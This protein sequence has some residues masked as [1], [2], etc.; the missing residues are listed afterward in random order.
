MI[1][2]NPNNTS[3]TINFVPRFYPT[4]AVTF[5]LYNEGTKGVVTLD[6]IY[7]VA[8]GIM[9]MTFDLVCKENEKYQIKLT[10]DGEILFRGKITA[11]SQTPQDFKATKDLYYYE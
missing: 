7:V 4:L 11:T 8:N 9:S 10:T 6:N 2:I 1:V 5:E 3:H